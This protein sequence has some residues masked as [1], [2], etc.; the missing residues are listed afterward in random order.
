MT[1]S[2]SSWLTVDDLPPFMPGIAPVTSGDAAAFAER[3][4]EPAQRQAFVSDHDGGDTLARWWLRLGE[5]TQ[6]TILVDCILADGALPYDL[7][8]AAVDSNPRRA[9]LLAAE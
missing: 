5:D 1:L 4:L 8:L 9:V 2:I 3:Y 7:R 6:H